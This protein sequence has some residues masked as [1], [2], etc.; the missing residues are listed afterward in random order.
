MSAVFETAPVI[1]EAQ[2]RS[3]HEKGF[4]VVED[5]YS[6]DDLRRMRA[7]LEALVEGARGV[8][9]NGPVYD[10]EPTHT[11]ERPRVRRIKEP[12]K[13]DPLFLEMARH[14]RLLAVLTALQGPA[15]RLHGAK[16]NLKSAGYGSPVE[17]HQDWAFYPH[18]NDNVLAVGVMLDDMTPDNGPLLCIPGS[19]TG[20]THDHHQDGRFHGAIDPQRSDIDF[21]S[22]EM[23]TGRAGS[24][25]F[26]HVRTVHGSALNTSGRD[27]RLLL[28]QTAAGDAWDLR[29][30][31]EKSWEAHQAT[32]LVGEAS[33]CPRLA[34][35]PVRLPYPAPVRGGSIYESQSVARN[36]YFQGPPG[37]ES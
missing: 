12:H 14:P 1:T 6:P 11:P 15:V 2:I 34:E 23:C 4:V 5:V 36:R 26:H 27:R 22:A 3:Y 31:A 8:G 17:W 30:L 16:I 25:S 7:T 18:T 33:V 19:H 29:G 13:A 32:M 20:P 9:E 28:Y 24:C 10:L 37:R 35:L 21:A